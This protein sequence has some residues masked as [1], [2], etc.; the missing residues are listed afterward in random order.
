M[1]H[2]QHRAAL[3]RL[4]AEQF[5]LE[6]FACHRVQTCKRF[7][8]QYDLRLDRQRFCNGDALLHAAAEL[9]GVVVFVPA[10]ADQIDELLCDCRILRFFVL[11]AHLERKLDVLQ[12]GLPVKKLVKILKDQNAV[13]AGLTKQFSAETYAS[14]ILLKAGNAP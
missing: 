9:V 2:K 6:R 5:A 11:A 1:G 10:Q 12:Y 8:H 7:V 13:N 4:Q 3:N 14:V